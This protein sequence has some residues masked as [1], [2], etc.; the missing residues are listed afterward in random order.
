ML[1]KGLLIYFGAIEPDSQD[2][3][4]QEQLA[5]DAVSQMG[6]TAKTGIQLRPAVFNHMLDKIRAPANY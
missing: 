1:I 3:K 4:D 2:D 5:Q 6:K